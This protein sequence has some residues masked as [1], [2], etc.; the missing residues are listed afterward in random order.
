MANPIKPWLD[1]AGRFPVT[2]IGGIPHFNESV[3]LDKPRTGVLHTTEG[4]WAGSLAVFRQHFAPHFMLGFDAE[5]GKVRIAQLVQ[6]GTIGAAIKAHNNQAIVQIEMIGFSKELPWLP[7]DDT[8]EALASLMAVCA[9]EYG[10]PLFHPWP[11]GDFGKA[12]N[13]PH[14][15]S[16]KYGTVAGWYGHGDCPSPDTHWDPGNLK[17]SIVL[18]KAT[19]IQAT[20]GT[21][22]LTAGPIA[23]AQARRAAA[24]A[25]GSPAAPRKRVGARK[26]A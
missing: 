22:H 23:M 26:R 17:W 1:Q 12:G 8:V 16:G 13:N 2:H 20:L 9:R 5:A 15:S 4:S 7:D 6:V 21:L 11:D 18:E 14:R 19:Q 24:A 25:A 10:I 3:L